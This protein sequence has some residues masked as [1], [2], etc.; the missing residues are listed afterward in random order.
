MGD[1]PACSIRMFAHM[2]VCRCSLQVRHFG[3]SWANKHELCSRGDSCVWGRWSV[4]LL[5]NGGPAASAKG[6][7]VWPHTFSPSPKAWREVFHK[8]HYNP[9]KLTGKKLLWQTFKIN[10]KMPGFIATFVSVYLAQNE[11]LE[12]LF[13]F[14]F[15]KSVDLKPDESVLF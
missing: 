5:T 14:F 6:H 9:S 12:M 2:L 4:W 13:F 1:T 3:K 15:H 11:K 7:M 10:Q 8:I